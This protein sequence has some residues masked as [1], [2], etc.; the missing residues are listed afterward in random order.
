MEEAMEGGRVVLPRAPESGEQAPDVENNPDIE[1]QWAV[2][3]F[4]HADVF[5]NLI[6]SVKDHSKI[7]LTKMDEDIYAVFRT[8][9]PSLKVDIINEDE[10]KSEESKQ[11]WRPFLMGFERKLPLFNFLTLLRLDASK[12]YEESNTTVVPRTQFW[13]IEIARLR[14]GHNRGVIKQ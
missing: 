6:S 9:F 14:E 1:K 11:K 12:G 3:A 2:T 7:H 4:H 13:A 8:V 10:L 5:M